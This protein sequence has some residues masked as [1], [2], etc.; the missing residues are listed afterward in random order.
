MRFGEWYKDLNQVISNSTWNQF[1]DLLRSEG[2]NSG[3]VPV[4][5]I[6]NEENRFN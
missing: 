5:D 3:K 4:S 1:N 2:F 6:P